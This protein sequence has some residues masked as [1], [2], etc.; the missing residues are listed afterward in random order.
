M[1]KF[2]IFIVL[3]LFLLACQE[4]PDMQKHT[5]DAA[6][7]SNET[8]PEATSAKTSPAEPTLSAMAFMDT[9][10]WDYRPVLVFEGGAKLADE[11][12][13][14]LMADPDGLDEREITVIRVPVEDAGT[15]TQDG[16]P[17]PS[18]RASDMRQHFEVGDGFALLLVG[19]DT[20]VKLRR[21]EPVNLT[22]IF[23]V[24][25]AMPMRRMEMRKQQYDGPH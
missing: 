9:L 15:V 6:A 13:E 22:M 20:G 2:S 5:S 7:R 19:K 23:D 16:L 25:D 24:I 1:F 12:I 10:A 21:T 8:S 18:L 4:Q 11:Q 14:A 17:R 3:T